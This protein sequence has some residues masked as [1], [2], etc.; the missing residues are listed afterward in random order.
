MNVSVCICPRAYKENYDLETVYITMFA[1]TK[2]APL[3]NAALH[4]RRYK[5]WLGIR[6]SCGMF[7]KNIARKFF[8]L[9]ADSSPS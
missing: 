6:Y 7:R 5:C 3:T 4:V 2:L 1:T 9:A 8:D